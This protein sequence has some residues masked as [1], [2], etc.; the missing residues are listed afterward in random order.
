VEL[1]VFQHGRDDV[2]LAPVSDF[3][4]APLLALNA[5][6]FGN[7]LDFGYRHIY[8]NRDSE[9]MARLC[10][11]HGAFSPRFIPDNLYYMHL[12]PPAIDDLYF[13]HVDLKADQLMGTSIWITTP[14][15][16][17]TFVGAGTW[18]RDPPRRAMMLGSL[19]VMI[20]LLCYH[21]PGFMQSGYNRFA[22][23]FIPVWLVLG[24]S[25][26]RGCRRSGLTLACIAWSLLYFRA[27]APQAPLAPRNS[28]AAHDKKIMRHMPD[29]PI[30]RE[31]RWLAS[32]RSC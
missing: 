28:A 1:A 3:A 11:A 4:A 25:Q 13:T 30:V 6:K 8:V 23:D 5:L 12:A 17:F 9:P 16:L 22:L 26:T 27:V 31:S 24:A 21:S 15:L 29:D 19:L 32:N 7:P 2:R 14:I 20:G 18:C 10:R